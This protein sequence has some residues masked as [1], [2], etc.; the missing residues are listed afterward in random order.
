MKL[1]P[2]TDFD[3]YYITEE[4]R[5]FCDLG[6]GCRDKTK[7]TEPYEVKPRPTRK[8]YLRVMVRLAGIG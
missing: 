6:K 2:I 7:R 5:V 8:G 3:G 4:G 1:I